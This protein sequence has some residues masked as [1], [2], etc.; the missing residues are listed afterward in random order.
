M[1]KGWGE[2]CGVFIIFVSVM[3]DLDALRRLGLPVMEIADAVNRQLAAGTRLVVTTPPGAGK[4]T[5][6]PLTLLAGMAQGKILMLEP[7]RLAARQ[8]R[9]GWRRCSGSRWAGR[10]GT[11]SASRAA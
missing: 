4:S 7:R 10:W 3:V 1:K 2:G 11:G 6:L 5:L 9:S 8:M